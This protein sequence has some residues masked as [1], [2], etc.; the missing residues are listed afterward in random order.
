MTLFAKIISFIFHPLFIAFYFLVFLLTTNPIYFSS[1]NT[2]IALVMVC[3]HTILFPGIAMLLLKKVELVDSLQITDKRQ[4]II[5]LII[6][7]ICYVWAFLSFKKVG[8]PYPYLWFFLGVLIALFL[9]FVINIFYKISLHMLSCGGIII[10]LITMFYYSQ[11]D[12]SY[13]FIGSILLTGI[14]AS[15]RLYL[16]AH[17]AREIAYGLIVGILAQ[18]IAIAIFQ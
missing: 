18:I 17:N 15:T 1:I 8:F 4:R 14:I 13:Y 12:I 11:S 5:P 3:Y 7:I 9:A 2:R 10:A 6:T 16:H